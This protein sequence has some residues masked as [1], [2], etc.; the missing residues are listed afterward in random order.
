[1]R[2]VSPLSEEQ[3]N[4]TGGDIYIVAAAPE[5]DK[6]LLNAR[7]V[8]ALDGAGRTL[9]LV[10]FGTARRVEGQVLRDVT[11][12]PSMARRSTAVRVMS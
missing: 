10:E 5:V 4:A 3:L 7:W 8:Q 9:A 12:R 2:V 1:V 6:E 11:A